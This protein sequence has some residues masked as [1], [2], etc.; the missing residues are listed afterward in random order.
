MLER[1]IGEK[2][3]KIGSGLVRGLIKVLDK[4]DEDHGVRTMKRKMLDSLNQRFADIE[5][6]D[7]LALA[8]L[9]DPRYKDKFFTT[10]SS[11]Q[12]AKE[13]LLSEYTYFLEDCEADET[14]EPPAKRPARDDDKDPNKAVGLCI[15]DHFRI[16]SSIPEEE[17]EIWE[18]NQ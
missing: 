16:L 7:F 11:C 15:R 8:T 14:D 10:S 17:T 12:Y 9:L 1:K 2:K 4:Q 13:M 3:S 18:I 6:I 5:D